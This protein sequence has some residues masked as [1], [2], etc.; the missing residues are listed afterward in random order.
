MGVQLGRNVTLPPPASKC[1]AGFDREFVGGCGR[2]SAHST[3]VLDSLD[4]SI[5]ANL[6]QWFVQGAR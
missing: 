3:G 4:L 5:N 1:R 6:E 2:L